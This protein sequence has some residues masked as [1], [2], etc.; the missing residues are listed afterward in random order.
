MDAVEEKTLKDC[1][2]CVLCFSVPSE[3]R[4]LVSDSGGVRV[5][6]GS[7][8]SNL[9][10]NIFPKNAAIVLRLKVLFW[11]VVIRKNR[12]FSCY[13]HFINTRVLCP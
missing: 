2:V 3:K 5:W 8:G 10:F 7:P 4:M 13:D 6:C 1:L 12:L 9:P 11:F